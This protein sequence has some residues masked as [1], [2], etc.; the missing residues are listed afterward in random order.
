[1]RKPLRVKCLEFRSVFMLIISNILVLL[2]LSTLGL[3]F[4]LQAAR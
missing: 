4:V 1:M 2:A 3:W